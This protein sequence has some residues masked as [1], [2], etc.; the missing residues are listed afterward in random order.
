M[1]LDPGGDQSLVTEGRRGRSRLAAMA[2][3]GTADCS[4]GWLAADDPAFVRWDVRDA[5]S[6][7]IYR[8]RKA[9]DAWLG[10]GFPAAHDTRS[11]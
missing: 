8:E 2:R 9:I 7:L 3:T 10:L 6:R 4:G 1:T 5:D 11:P